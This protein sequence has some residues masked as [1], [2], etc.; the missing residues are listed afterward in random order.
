MTLRIIGAFVLLLDIVA[1]IA[2]SSPAAD[3]GMATSTAT[4]T[5]ELFGSIF[6]GDTCAPP[7]W[8]G[9]TSGES[10]AAE[11]WEFLHHSEYI[12]PA[13]DDTGGRVD[14][15]TGYL[16]DGY[17]NFAL[18]PW[19]RCNDIVLNGVGSA[20]IEDGILSSLWVTPNE[21]ITLGRTLAV[22]EN[23]DIVRLTPGEITS[24]EFI[25]L[26]MNVRVELAAPEEDDCVAPSL[27][28]E[29]IA[30]RVT[31]YSPQAAMQPAK[32]AVGDAPQPRLVAYYHPGERN[33]PLDIWEEWLDGTVEGQCDEIWRIL[34]DP[35]LMPPTTPTPPPSFTSTPITPEFTGSI[36]AHDICAPPCWFGLVPGESAAGEV[37][38]FLHHSEYVSTAYADAEDR[39]DPETGYLMD[40]SYHFSLHPWLRC[41]NVLWEGSFIR[42]E[43]GVFS[44]LQA[45]LNE[46][47]TLDQVLAAWGAPD[48]VRLTPVEATFLDL[49]YLDWNV[50]I[51]LFAPSGSGCNLAELKE[52]FVVDTVWYYSS[53]AAAE[54]DEYMPA[55]APQPRLVG[56]H[57][58]ERNVPLEV[59]ETWLSGE[60]H[61]ECWIAARELPDE[62]V[63]PELTPPVTPAPSSTAT[64]STIH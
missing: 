17:Y 39:F 25:Y 6:A 30:F 58:A 21:C 2:P 35:G 46:C 23:P 60:V 44:Y 59:W 36:F 55:E 4:P 3:A 56:Y 18:T 10:T 26:D 64:P 15:E 42:I 53:E 9:L 5:P 57:R 32:Y 33:V 28:R 29:F 13:V 19:S 47:I 40:G 61:E 27:R 1:L 16:A 50:R 41:D 38:G 43:N 49:I 8:F 7:C 52:E 31:Y 11:V 45:L 12:F 62:R 63:Y 37:W 54:L 20:R 48:I 51:S 22:W 24:L 14:P 34:P